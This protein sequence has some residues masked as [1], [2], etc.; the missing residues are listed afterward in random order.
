MNSVQKD[1]IKATI[2][3]LRTGGEALTDHFYKR[4]F[5]H[6]PELKEIFNM[7]NQA[8]GRQKAALA[9]AVLAYAEHIDN[10]GVLID[11]LKG[12][13]SKHTSLNIQPEQYQIVGMHLIAS[14]KEVIGDGATPE[15]LEAW[16][17][18]YNQL[19]DIMINLEKGMYEENK[20]KR[21][22]WNGWRKFIV[23]RIVEESDEIKSFY[24]YPED[25]KEIASFFAGQFISVQV[26]VPE[27]NLLQPRQYSLSN[28]FHPEYYRI[29]VKKEVGNPSSPSGMVSNALHAKSEGDIITISA[30]AGVFHLPED[31]KTPLVLISG[32][33][34]FTP[35][36]SMLETN[37]EQIQ[38]NKLVWIHG[39]RNQS[40]HAFKNEINS[41]NEEAQWLDT[42]IFYEDVNSVNPEDG[43]ISGRVNLE[44]CKEAILLD[45]AHYYICGPA[46]FI[47]AQYTSLVDLNVNTKN[48]FYEEFGPQAIQLN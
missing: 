38:N 19:A 33:V 22:G 29:S 46:P 15:I 11:V 31:H 17:I 26:F 8:N 25:G 37:K 39:C 23:K 36:M 14:I 6:N 41:L 35:M 3:I 24:L 28:A 4:M 27:L 43:V 12:I 10:P 34:G 32:G 30:P 5:L 13:G 1:L 47:K 48:I 7:G 2:P 20:I 9:M 16:T 45:D 18:A 21:G 40:V 42:Y 44:L